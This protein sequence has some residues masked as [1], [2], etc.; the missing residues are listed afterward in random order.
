[1]VINVDGNSFKLYAFSLTHTEGK[2]QPLLLIAEGKMTPHDAYV[3]LPDGKFM[4]Y[5]KTGSYAIW[6]CSAG[7]MHFHNPAFK[8]GNTCEELTRGSLNSDPRDPSTWAKMST[9]SRTGKIL[10]AEPS[11]KLPDLS[12]HDAIP[13][14]KASEHRNLV[15]LL[16]NADKQQVAS[17]QPASHPAVTTITDSSDGFST[18]SKV[19]MVESHADKLSAASHH[20]PAAK[21]LAV[22]DTFS[23]EFK[24]DEVDL[25]KSKLQQTRSELGST[26][27]E[28]DR[29]RKRVTD[30][31]AKNVELEHV[32]TTDE[33]DEKSLKAKLRDTESKLKAQVE[34]NEK[35][36]ADFR[37][38]E[39]EDKKIMEAEF[40]TKLQKFREE[41]AH[42][43]DHE[44]NSI[45]K[46]LAT[47]NQPE[48][49]KDSLPAPVPTL[50]SLPLG[51]APVEATL[52]TPP[53]AA[54][55]VAT[56]ATPVTD[57]KT[58]PS[59]DW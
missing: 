4:A 58:P 42:E 37:A 8:Y 48:Q 25:L 13:V 40:A 27:D 30:V 17:V 54:T 57:T 26:E 44:R 1:L 38:R 24:K 31:E 59:S 21:D 51:A 22:H 53:P 36:V 11:Q 10:M 45:S 12:A 18:P 55:V 41:L 14:Q 34:A 9:T 15:N 29:L 16:Q 20:L 28:V 52:V 3:G 49:T 33:S 39:A 43:F 19:V 23:T 7:Q 50:P 32:A 2:G 5:N 47:K 56:K 46:L 6:Q 35:A